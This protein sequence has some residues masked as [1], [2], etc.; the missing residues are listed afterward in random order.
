MM[1]PVRLKILVSL[2][3]NYDI[4]QNIGVFWLSQLTETTKIYVEETLFVCSL[5]N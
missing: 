1:N 4:Y 3:F 5:S 2:H